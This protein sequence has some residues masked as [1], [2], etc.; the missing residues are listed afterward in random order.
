MSCYNF[1][2]QKTLLGDLK[3]TAII[4][5]IRRGVGQMELNPDSMSELDNRNRKNKYPICRCQRNYSGNF[6]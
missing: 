2:E 3:R 1:A 5:P 4:P 6:L